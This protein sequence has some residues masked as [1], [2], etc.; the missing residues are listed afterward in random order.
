MEKITV[1]ST[2]DGKDYEKVTM[3]GAFTKSRLLPLVLC[4]AIPVAVLQ[5]MEVINSGVI[6]NKFAYYGSVFMLSLIIFMY[7][8]VKMSI[9]SFVKNDKVL[10]G[11]QRKF[12]IDEKSI[13]TISSDHVKNNYDYNRFIDA[14]E[15]NGYFLLYMDKV[16]GLVITKRDME[17]ADIET[18]RK[19]L[20]NAFGRKFQIRGKK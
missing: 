7:A 17:Q 4:F 12:V 18:F 6:H 13:T 16:S 14:Y 9:R 3:F 20:K 8:M 10:L 1:K 2:L 15:I 5:I 11:K 19:V